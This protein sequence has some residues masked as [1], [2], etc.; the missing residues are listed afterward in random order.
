MNTAK[1][2]P[3]SKIAL[4]PNQHVFNTQ[5]HRKV[6][7]QSTIIHHNRLLILGLLIFNIVLAY[8]VIQLNYFKAETLENK[9]NQQSINEESIPMTPPQLKLIPASE[10]A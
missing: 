8:Q 2:Q 3:K 7:R 9:I 5:I 1:Q 10:L 4:L 6:L